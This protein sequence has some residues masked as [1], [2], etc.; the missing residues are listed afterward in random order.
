MNPKRPNTRPKVMQNERKE[1]KMI[2]K[3]ERQTGLEANLPVE[4]VLV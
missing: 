3:T 4:H 2:K 1:A